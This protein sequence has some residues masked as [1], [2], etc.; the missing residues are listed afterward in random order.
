MDLRCDSLVKFVWIWNCS[1][2]C[3]PPDVSSGGV[4][5]RR[6]RERERAGPS[7]GA[8]LAGLKSS[9]VG[10]FMVQLREQR[11]GRRREE[12]GMA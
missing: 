10:C 7:G 6:E 8:S 11:G 4:A 2:C 9:S 1:D 12:G 3:W 5:L